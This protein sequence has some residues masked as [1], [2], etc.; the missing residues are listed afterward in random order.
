MDK[1]QMSAILKTKPGKIAMLFIVLSVFSLLG[2]FIDIANLVT[3]IIGAIIFFF[4]SGIFFL[5]GKK[6]V[7]NPT[8]TSGSTPAASVQDTHASTIPI[9]KITKPKFKPTKKVEKYFYIDDENKQWCVPCSKESKAVYNYSDLLDFEL[10][11]DGGTVTSGSLGRAIAGGLAFGGLG[12]VVGGM[13]GKQKQT[14]SKLQIKITVKDIKHP[15]L[16]IN[17][18]DFEVKKDNMIYKNCIDSAQEIISL[19]QVIKAINE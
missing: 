11:E 19:L 9:S 3:G 16:Y 5:K 15:A 12:A 17:L 8:E 10:I 14:C 4:V 1:Q 7:E 2:G 6:E 13:T 18:L